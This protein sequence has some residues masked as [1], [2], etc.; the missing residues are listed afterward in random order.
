[1]WNNDTLYFKIGDKWKR[2]PS[3]LEQEKWMKPATLFTLKMGDTCARSGHAVSNKN[4][5][6][7][8]I[9]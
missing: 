8:G 7:Y 4:T 1:M 6:R 2:W 5:V 3:P 9:V